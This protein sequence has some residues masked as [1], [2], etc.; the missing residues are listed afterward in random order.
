[1][2]IYEL[3][4]TTENKFS[5]LRIS[6]LQISQKFDFQ[7]KKDYIL[8][9][10]K[11]KDTG[12][13]PPSPDNNF[14]DTNAALFHGALGT[15]KRVQTFLERINDK[16]AIMLPYHGDIHYSYKIIDHKQATADFKDRYAFFGPGPYVWDTRRNSVVLWI[17][18]EEHIKD[19]RYTKYKTGDSFF[20]GYF[21]QFSDKQNRNQL[22]FV[23]FEKKDSH[24]NVGIYECP[25]TDPREE[26]PSPLDVRRPGYG[27][28]VAFPWQ[29]LYPDIVIL[30]FQQ[31]S[32][33]PN[34]ESRAWD[35][36]NTAMATSS[37]TNTQ[38]DFTQ[39]TQDAQ[40]I[41]KTRENIEKLLSGIESK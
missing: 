17:P 32:L 1:M 20:S 2:A 29:R 39:L 12:L 24:Y 10:M 34:P 5:I 28:P 14:S 22:I 7:D 9:H 27:Y 18:Y 6:N 15:R 4:W 30:P 19:F 41:S 26:S 36:L 21:V 31:G 23:G 11:D 35:N 37:F 40:F 3:G 38:S 8:N 33:E 25:V 13:I 16:N